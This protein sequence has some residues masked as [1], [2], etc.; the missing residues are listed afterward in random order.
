MATFTYIADFTASKGVKPRVRAVR[1]G[2]GYEQ[3]TAD[4]INTQPA[5]WALSFNIRTDTE[6]NAI[7]T[8][9]ATQAGITVF[10]WTPPSG[11]AMRVI[12]R[13]WNRVAQAYNVNSITCTF[14]Q[15]FE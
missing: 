12:C 15:V 2:D 14:E 8:F 5:A 11:S 1:F 4:G 6:A 7:E 13:E 10:D 9:L 3:R